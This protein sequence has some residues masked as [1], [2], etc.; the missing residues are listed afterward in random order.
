LIRSQ[1]GRQAVDSDRGPPPVEL[2]GLDVRPESLPD[3]PG[4]EAWRLWLAGD[5][6]GCLGLLYRAALA[7]LIHQ[8]D[9][10]IG[11]SATEADCVGLVG[12]IDRPPLARY[13]GGLTAV[14]QT[15][16]YAHRVPAEPT[17]RRLCD[18]W[19]RHFRVGG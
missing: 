4:A 17:V 15:V 12:G 7:G 8:H 3:D 14:W 9:L 18:E 1:Q 19:P 11:R 16:A 13:F 10:A 5:A 2:M 6:A